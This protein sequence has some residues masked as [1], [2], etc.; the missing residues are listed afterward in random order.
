[1]KK[2]FTMLLVGVFVLA[3]TAM[4]QKSGA[5]GTKSAASL[6]ATLEQREKEGWESFK[7]KDGKAYAALCAEE[8][9]GV[10]EDGAGEH[11]LNS[12]LESM[13]QITINSYQLGDLQ[14]TA[15]GPNAAMVRY[16]AEANVTLGDGPAQDSKMAV[17]D[18]W[19]KRGGQWKS[20]RYQETNIK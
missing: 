19:V 14:V 5:S 6:Q 15:L 8:Y 1:M 9:T 18:I 17:T 20:V 3:G 13:N 16:T 11:D 10:Y 4:A 2:S 12:A 7:N